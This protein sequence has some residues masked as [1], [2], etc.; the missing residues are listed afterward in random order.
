MSNE[1]Y[2]EASQEERRHFEQCADC[3][4]W[5]DCRSLD[6]VFFHCTDHQPRPDIPCGPCWPPQEC[7]Y[8]HQPAPAPRAK[9]PPPGYICQHCGRASAVDVKAGA[10][11]LRPLSE[12]ERI[13]IA[14]AIRDFIDGQ[15][16]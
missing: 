6:E 4:E 9:K 8:C 5:F 12:D 15:E 11:S 3:G 1:A 10:C 13:L 14:Q 16:L 2:N 7:P